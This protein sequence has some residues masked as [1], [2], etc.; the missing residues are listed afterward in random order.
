[1]LK[2]AFLMD[3]VR[4][5]NPAKDSSFA[6]ML[7]AHKRNHRL[8]CFDSQHMHADKKAVTAQVFEIEVFDRA[9]NFVKITK[10]IILNLASVDVILMRKNPP[11]NMNYIYATYL[12]EY[13]EQQGVLVV[14]KPRAL[15]DFNE[16][17]AIMRFPDYIT[18]TLISS[19]I[20]QLM[21]FIR[22][23]K[24]TVVKPLD[25]MGGENIF[26]LKVDDNK[27]YI[28]DILNKLTYFGTTPIMSQR[29]L[30]AI[31][32]GDKRILII[33]GEPLPYVLARMPKKGS[34]K[35]NLAAGATGVGQKLS[36]HD[37]YLCTQIAPTLTQNGLIFVGLDVIGDYISEINVTSPTGIRELDKIYHIHIAD[38]LLDTIENKLS[39]NALTS[40]H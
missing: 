36:T 28:I 1:M 21:V 4:R 37:K 3:D 33:D 39:N 22:E 14:N 17:L 29:Y 15:R 5:I 25:G 26:K 12:L 30:T 27:K 24:T 19:D 35:G 18:D 11:F 23:Q 8:F 40:S 2:I 20:E 9:D 16:K 7:S 13:L 31:A 34:F 6:M 10:Q 38:I 32:R